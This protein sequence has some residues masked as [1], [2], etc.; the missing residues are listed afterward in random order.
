[1]LIFG[2]IKAITD[3]QGNWSSWWQ[4]IIVGM[5]L[6]AFVL[7]QKVIKPRQAKAA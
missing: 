6:L 2:I 7:L 5:L 3:F 1:M 4:K